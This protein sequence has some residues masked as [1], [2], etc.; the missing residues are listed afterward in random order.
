VVERKVEAGFSPAGV[1][2]RTGGEAGHAAGVPRRERNFEAVG[3]GVGKPVNG[4]RPKVVVFALFAIGDDGR[5]VAS[6][7]AMVSRMASSKS[8]EGRIGGVFA[9]D[10]VDQSLG[11]WD[12]TDG[13]CGELDGHLGVRE[14]DG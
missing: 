11:P 5:P 6:K 7:R 2:K 3:V 4:V 8:I 13:F 1:A 10:G 9:A 12:A 14:S